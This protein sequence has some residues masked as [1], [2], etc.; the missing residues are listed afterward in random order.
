VPRRHRCSAGGTGLCSENK[1]A[2]VS[3]IISSIRN[4]PSH[5]IPQIFFPRFTTIKHPC[6]RKL[7]AQN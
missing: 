2:T 5:L 3:L 4:S 6:K 1:P 7:R